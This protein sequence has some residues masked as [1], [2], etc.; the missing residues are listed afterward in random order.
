MIESCNSVGIVGQFG[1]L[2]VCSTGVRMTS[3]YANGGYENA[4]LIKEYLASGD[5]V[6]TVQPVIEHP[7]QECSGL[8]T[9]PRQLEE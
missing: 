3:F 6:P 5:L 2:T 1:P 9:L 7:Y 4:T 8:G